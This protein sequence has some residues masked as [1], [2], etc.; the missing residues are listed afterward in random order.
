MQHMFI[1]QTLLIYNSAIISG[2]ILQQRI[3]SDFKWAKELFEKIKTLLQL[4]N[5]T[6]RNFPVCVLFSNLLYASG[7]AELLQV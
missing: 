7:M 6:L 1:L 4:R 3:R 5:L 2:H